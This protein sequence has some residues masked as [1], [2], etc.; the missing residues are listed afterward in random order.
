MDTQ[1]LIT[2]V[3]GRGGDFIVDG[4]KITVVPKGVL[5]SD[6]RD[7]LV[8]NKLSVLSA[9]TGKDFEGESFEAERPARKPK[10]KARVTPMQHVD[11]TR[12]ERFSK[13]V[14]HTIPESCLTG[15]NFASGHK[16]LL[17]FIEELE[18]ENPGC[19]IVV[20]PNGF[21]FS[22]SLSVFADD[23]ESG[24]EVLLKDVEW[25]RWSFDEA[26]VQMLQNKA[27]SEKVRAAETYPSM[28]LSAAR[29]E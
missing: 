21:A 2:N 9:L 26:G 10:A 24:E 13:G 23:C 22:V 12:T 20:N 14:Y 15:R 17:E 8:A 3:R 27:R 6:E 7:Y 5:E 16:S 29:D 11:R 4:L 25:Q 19:R 1:T 18:A 28:A